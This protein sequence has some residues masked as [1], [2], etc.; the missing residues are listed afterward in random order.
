MKRSI[1]AREDMTVRTALLETRFLAG[2][3][4]LFDELTRRF[5]TDVI[6]GTAADFI[7]AKL[8]EE[9]DERHKKAGETRYLVEPNVKESKDG[10]RDLQTLFWITKYY[11]RIRSPEQLVTI[12]VLSRQEARIFRKADDFLWTVRAHMHFLAG[13]TQEGLCRLTSRVKSPTGSA[14]RANPGMQDVE[15]FMKHYFLWLPNRWAI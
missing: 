3:R 4:L 12:G 11:Y 13:K 7:R 9:R 15:R 5:E 14:I 6:K 10:Q 1:Y 8:T 2:N